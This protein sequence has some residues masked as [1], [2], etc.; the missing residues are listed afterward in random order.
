MRPDLMIDQS[1]VS[2]IKQHVLNDPEILPIDRMGGDG[3]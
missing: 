2:V 3:N 1:I